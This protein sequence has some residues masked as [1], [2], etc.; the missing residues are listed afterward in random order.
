MET[1]CLCSS[2]G[3]K[4]GGLKQQKHLPLGFAIGGLQPFPRDS[5][6]KDLG[7]GLTG[8]IKLI[9]CTLVATPSERLVRHS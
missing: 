5:N 6:N 8:T 4:H 7:G 2:E 1:P 9:N 3:H